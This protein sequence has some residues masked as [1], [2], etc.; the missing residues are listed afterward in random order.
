MRRP[1]RPGEQLGT[2]L[3]LARSPQ[4]KGRIERCWGTQ[5]DRLVKALRRAGA[6]SLDE[7]NAV[8][9]DYLPR[10][11]ARFAVA[12][13]DR[14]DAHHRLPRRLDLDGVCS[15]HYVRRVANDNTV[16]LEERLVQIPPGPRRR[17]YA[18]CRV[19]LQ[20][21]LDGELVVL[22]QGAVIARLPAVPGAV[23]VARQRRRGRELLADP[24]IPRPV[25]EPIP[26]IDLPAD[27]FPQPRQHPWRRDLMMHRKDKNKGLQ[28]QRAEAPL[29]IP[30]K[31][32]II[33]P[34]SAK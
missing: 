4:A 34:Q 9:A 10:H 33:L 5:Q 24:P 12:P 13:A 27:V 16:R 23:L 3:I 6:C 19:E 11:N 14:T 1:A 32:C 28:R 2:Q 17:S 31:E 22:Y 26:D 25:P 8:L 15:F 30:S 29:S 20:E 7:A 18:R 21:R